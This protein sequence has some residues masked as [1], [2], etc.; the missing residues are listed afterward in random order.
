VGRPGDRRGPVNAAAAAP[1]GAGAPYT[2]QAVRPDGTTERG[3]VQ[4]GSRD[5]ALAIVRA[6]G[7]LPTAVRADTHRSRR[8]RVPPADL[9]LGL[10]ILSDLID[11]GLPM[12]RALATLEELA[13]PS[14]QAGMPALRQAVREGRSLAAAFQASG[15]ELPPLVIGVMQ[16]G[17]A[18][19]GL[20]A[21]V[22]RA[23][24][25]TETAAATRAAIRAALAYPAVLAAASSAAVALLVGVVLPRFAVILIDLGQTLPPT[26][27]AV[28]AAADAV[29]AGA[30]PALIT[31]T[32]LLVVWRVW[33][34]T[35]DGRRRWH[36]ALLGAPVIGGIR[37]AAGTAHAA[38][39]LASLLESGVPLPV[40]LAHSARATGDGALE[41]RLL[42]VREGVL[43]GRRISA[44]CAEAHAMTST[45][46]RLVRAG[47]D[48]GR[49]AAML[50]HAAKL[51]GE[52][53]QQMVRRA[54]H[55]LEPMLILGFGGVIALVAAALLQAVYGVR[56]GV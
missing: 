48:T 31:V 18:G 33:T 38:A 52:R 10:R 24:D 1:S 13:P 47:E 27:R 16:A 43:T 2:Y 25:F 45:A 23:A 9:A 8:V 40:A 53:A 14:W 26:T 42:A 22:R 55:L 11:A 5:A 12:S 50:R 54:V 44:A 15:L 34:A 28:L 3:T 36:T 51:E 56:P 35:P 49:L 37:H 46:I 19:S 20:A 29:R 32:L 7:L 41:H 30:A 39:A 21:A 6:R 17:E 4:A